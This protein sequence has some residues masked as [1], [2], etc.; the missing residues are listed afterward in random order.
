MN[1]LDPRL[2]QIV[3]QVGDTQTVFGGELFIRAQGTL[4]ANALQDIAEVVIYN[5]ERSTQDY[6]MN[7]MSPYSMDHRAKTLKILAGRKSYGMTLIYQGTV[8]VANIS[9]PPDIGVTFTCLSGASFQNTVYSTQL[10]GNNSIET[11]AT[12]AA[13]RFNASTRVQLPYYPKIANYAFSGTPI[14]ELEYINSFGNISIFLTE[15]NTNVLTVKGSTVPLTGTLRQV[16]EE[17]GMIGVPEWT[18]LGIR[19]TFFID[20]KTTLGGGIQLTSKRYPTF[21]GVYVIFKLNFDLANRE[22]PFYYI[23]E[24]ARVIQRGEAITP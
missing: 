15:G 17:T 8:M 1:E 10:A 3:I 22:K 5:M 16:S 2:L 12:Q 19:V 14:Q 7:I 11:I 18:E 9:Q 4:F 23:A 21:N 6:L 13:Q 20:N 24:A